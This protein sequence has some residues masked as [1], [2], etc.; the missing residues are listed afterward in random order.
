MNRTSASHA[1]LLLASLSLG[2][3]SCADNRS[4]DI[5]GMYNPYPDGGGGGDDGADDGGDDGGGDDGGSGTGGDGDDGDDGTSGDGSDDG[6]SGDGGDGGTT[7]EEV[8]PE[9]PYQGGWDIGTCQ[10]DIQGNAASP[11]AANVGAVLMDWTLPD[12]FGDQVRLYDFCHEVVYYV[13]VAGW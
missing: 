11:Q 10:D 3:W 12:Q 1:L 6:T 5:D 9:S 7:T 8:P 2:L 4:D 13:V